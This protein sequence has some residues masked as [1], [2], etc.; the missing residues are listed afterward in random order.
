MNN[1]TYSAIFKVS[2]SGGTGSCFYLDGY[3]VFV[4]NYHVVEGYHE[5]A[6]KGLD[7]EARMAQVFLANPTLDIA[8]L[9]SPGNDFSHL[10]R[11]R[12][13]KREAA[14]GETIRVAG[15]PLGM[16]FSVTEGTISAPRQ[17][18]NDQTYIQTDAAINPGN[19]GGPLLNAKDEVIGIAVS[20]F[21]NAENTGFAIPVERLAQILDSAKGKD[22]ARFH[23]QCG[24]CGEAID[25]S[26]DYCPSCGEK[27][28]EGAFDEEHI[29]PLSAFSERAIVM[30]GVN[31]KLA[32][33]GYEQWAFHKGSSYIRMYVYDDTY[34]FVTS[35]MNLLPQKNLEPILTY[36]LTTNFSPYKIGLEGRRI[37]LDYRIHLSDIK[38]ETETKIMQEIAQ[39]AFTAD[40]LDD[41]LVEKFGCKFTPYSNV[42]KGT[43]MPKAK[44]KGLLGWFLGGE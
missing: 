39:L 16:P 28:P 20:K 40:D 38:P 34:L 7:G 44:R 15:F 6:I 25:T 8:L 21:T 29:S 5:V 31:P 22:T 2:H 18:I 4:T 27:L 3:K 32:R 12:L 19:S 14:R 11:L 41:M 23:I 10:P 1:N 17:R 35:P 30:M 33:A 43:Q 9:S 13:A 24:S 42:K 36:M 26:S 37:D